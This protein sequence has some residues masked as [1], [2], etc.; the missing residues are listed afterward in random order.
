MFSTKI[1]YGRSAVASVKTRRCDRPSEIAN[2]STSPA[3]MAR[4]MSSAS[5][6]LHQRLLE[7]R[8]HVRWCAG[9]FGELDEFRVA[10]SPVPGSTARRGR[11]AT[12]GQCESCL[13]RRCLAHVRDARKIQCLARPC[14]F[15]TG[16]QR[17][18]EPAPEGSSPVSVSPRG[19][20]STDSLGSSWISTTEQVIAAA[21]VPITKTGG[22]GYCAGRKRR[23][24]ADEESE[25]VEHFFGRDGDIEPVRRLIGCGC[26]VAPATPVA[27]SGELTRTH[28]HSRQERDRCRRRRSHRLDAAGLVRRVGRLGRR[29]PSSRG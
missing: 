28:V 14:R 27:A 12:V 21:A 24:T 15:A 26:H 10:S 1:R 23:R 16:R 29:H 3:A 11:A 2:A 20:R 5:D 6:I 13:S 4:N 9:R 8:W 7:R 19:C 17:P 22:V 25:F 18:G